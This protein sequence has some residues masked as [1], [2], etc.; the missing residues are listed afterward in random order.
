MSSKDSKDL[1][2]VVYS[3]EKKNIDDDDYEDDDVY[4]EDQNNTIAI[5][6]PSDNFV[7]DHNLFWKKLSQVQ[8]IRSRTI[9]SR[10]NDRSFV[11]KIAAKL[12]K[13]NP[14]TQNFSNDILKDYL[15][16]VALKYNVHYRI[17]LY[18]GIPD[19]DELF[20]VLEKTPIKL[21]VQEP[22]QSSKPKIESVK[23]MNVDLLNASSIDTYLTFKKQADSYRKQAEAA[24]SQ[25]YKSPENV[26]IAQ[27]AV[28]K[29]RESLENAHKTAVIIGSDIFKLIK[30][31]TYYMQTFKELYPVYKYERD[32]IRL[33]HIAPLAKQILINTGK[34]NHVDVAGRLNRLIQSV[35][36]A[37]NYSF[38]LNDIQFIETEW[39]T[40]T[41][42]HIHIPLDEGIN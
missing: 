33:Y 23:L 22:K 19:D 15:H 8:I 5:S 9:S 32:V 4:M 24:K 31:N 29:Y 20:S 40:E 25:K 26:K 11:I 12:L 38:N 35:L 41:I 18:E 27:N 28:E 3:N 21:P 1:E 14:L 17:D 6:Y 30:S 42:I 37:Y 7:F 13:E 34:F 16:Q 39:H 10:I 2:F 36:E